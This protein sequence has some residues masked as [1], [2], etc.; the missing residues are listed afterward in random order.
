MA[1]WVPMKG[2]AMNIMFHSCNGFG[3]NVD[4]S[5]DLS[6][7][8][9]LWR[10]VLNT[11]QARPFHV[12]VGGG[13]QIFNDSVLHRCQRFRE[14]YETRNALEKYSSPFSSEMQAELEE[15]YLAQYCKWFSQGLFS[16]AAS[17]IPM[18]NILDDHEVI[19]GYGSYP[20]R[21]MDSPVFSGLGAVAFKYY[22]LFQHQSVVDETE[23]SEPSWILGAAPGPYIKEY[24]RNVIVDLGS[25][26]SLLAVDCR[27]ERT[28]LDIIAEETWEKI[29]DRCYKDVKSGSTEHLLVVLP[30]PIAYPRMV[31]LENILSS[32]L[33]RPVK[34]VGKTGVLGAKLNQLDSG[35]DALDDLSDHWTAKAH[36]GERRDVVEQLQDLA[37][38]KS[39]R[40]TILRL[41]GGGDPEYE[42]GD[43]AAFTARPMRSARPLSPEDISGNFVPKPFHRTPTGLSTKQ[44]KR[45]DDFAVDLEG[46]LDISLNV[47]VNPKDPAGITVPYR[48]LVPRLFHD[49]DDEKKHNALLASEQPSGFKRLLSFR[50]TAY[51]KRKRHTSRASLFSPQ[52]SPPELLPIAPNEERY[53]YDTVSSGDRYDSQGDVLDVRLD[54]AQSID[55]GFLFLVRFFM[56]IGHYKDPALNT[57]DSFC[58][59]L[60]LHIIVTY[61]LRR[62]ARINVHLGV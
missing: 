34:A 29:M 8:D 35:G 21:A 36:K 31:W 7:P 18:V 10:D 22:M 17:Q 32:R 37:A 40:V 48:I 3:L 30:V 11:H 23:A 42:Q 55:E 43:E 26:I 52:T 12:M 9:P 62:R 50:E 4:N 56:D 45:A 39:V 2:K 13:G 51:H 5:D 1:F 44:R 20:R 41:R 15:Y 19:D 58:A 57:A 38:I 53:G 28:E 25:R 47:E 27:T 61:P 59:G 46:G 49:E 33:M 14:W 6:G 60:G 24:S 16:L 54:A